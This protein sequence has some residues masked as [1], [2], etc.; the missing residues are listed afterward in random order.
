MSNSTFLKVCLGLVFLSAPASDQASAKDETSVKDFSK[1]S[2]VIEESK[3]NVVFQNDGTFVN[4]QHVR[5]RIQ[6]D[7]GVRQYGILSFPYQA[8]SGTVEVR[9]VRVIKP[10]GAAIVTDLSSIQDITSEMSRQAPMYSD[11][12]EKHVPV[13]GLEP[14]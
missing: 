3:S 1:E 7:A 12:R 10:N 6:S 9:D 5:V 13:K 8:S 4:D 11:M 14:G 2:V